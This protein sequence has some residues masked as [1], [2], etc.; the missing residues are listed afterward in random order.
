MFNRCNY[1][2]II[3]KFSVEKFQASAGILKGRD[4]AM[5]T[6]ESRW[7]DGQVSRPPGALRL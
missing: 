1:N 2:D 7:A 3:R 4:V 5:T 6:T